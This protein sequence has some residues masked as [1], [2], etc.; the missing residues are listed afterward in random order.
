M[1]D[2]GG[3]GGGGLFIKMMSWV[4]FALKPITAKNLI[5]FCSINQ[6]SRWSQAELHMTFFVV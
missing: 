4:L 1:E 5:F 3:G 6:Y 2:G